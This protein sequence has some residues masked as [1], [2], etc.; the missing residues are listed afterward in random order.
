MPSSVSYAYTCALCD[1]DAVTAASLVSHTKRCAR[2]TLTEG[3]AEQQRRVVSGDVTKPATCTQCGQFASF[4]VEIFTEH[5]TYCE[6]EMS[7]RAEM[8]DLTTRPTVKSVVCVPKTSALHVSPV[9]M[10]KLD[11][12][13]QP[14]VPLPPLI[15]APP[16]AV[17]TAVQYE[18]TQGASRSKKRRIQRRNF[19]RKLTGSATEAAAV[20][21]KIKPLTPNAST[22]GLP[23]TPARRRRQARQAQVHSLILSATPATA[24]IVQPPNEAT[25]SLVTMT[26]LTT[27]PNP[28]ISSIASDSSDDLPCITAGRSRKRRH[29]RHVP[30]DR[31]ASVTS[32]S[33]ESVGSQEML[34]YKV[35]FDNIYEPG[36]SVVRHLARAI[37]R[38]KFAEAAGEVTCSPTHHNHTRQVVLGDRDRSTGGDIAITESEAEPTFT[39]LR[40]AK[41]HVKRPVYLISGRMQARDPNDRAKTFELSLSSMPTARSASFI[42]QS[43]DH[44]IPALIQTRER[45]TGPVGVLPIEWPATYAWGAVLF[46]RAVEPPQF[47]GYIAVKEQLRLQRYNL[48]QSNGVHC[49]ARVRRVASTFY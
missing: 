35:Q 36:R 29:H 33:S 17:I 40:P 18:S 7:V 3:E 26:D 19:N 39:K 5:E 2:L 45:A 41:L 22:E 32:T 30:T 44:F 21:A 8:D 24:T 28:E 34:P 38:A 12:L 20:V 1:H 4:D 23:R 46:N 11:I 13:P 9:I 10:K 31:A 16:A 14:E 37:Q 49:P 48:R 6:A 25:R 42:T 27:A 43:G 47:L 15:P